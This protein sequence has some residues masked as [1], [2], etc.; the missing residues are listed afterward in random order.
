MTE[1][2][3][4][5]PLPKFPLGQIVATPGAIALL[6]R[7]EIPALAL[8]TRHVLGDWGDVD[9]EDA[10]ENNFSLTHGF[11]LLSAYELPTGGSGESSAS[12][13]ETLWI[14]T[15]ADRAVT[16]LLLPREY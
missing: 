1:A 14:I 3:K 12:A 8:L 13:V 5:P 9:A 4:P 2:S 7:A 10:Q 11:R 16:T 6:A 15:E